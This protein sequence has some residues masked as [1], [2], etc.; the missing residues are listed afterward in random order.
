[1]QGHRGIQSQ[2]A[3]AANHMAYEYVKEQAIRQGLCTE[4]E[5]DSRAEFRPVIYNVMLSFAAPKIIA[6]HAHFDRLAFPPA[7]LN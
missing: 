5:F 1:M 7:Y 6:Q 3:T 4:A 2:V